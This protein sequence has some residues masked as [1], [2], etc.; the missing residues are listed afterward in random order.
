MKVNGILSDAID[1]HF[2]KPVETL[3]SVDSAPTYIASEN[4]SYNLK[5]M[6]TTGGSVMLAA[7]GMFAAYKAFKSCNKKEDSDDFTKASKL[8]A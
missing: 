2:T 1:N 5:N 3:M 7:I 4:E 8:L 6:A